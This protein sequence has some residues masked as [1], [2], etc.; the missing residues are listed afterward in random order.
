M[1][2]F[3]IGFGYD[4]HQLVENRPLVLG[5]IHISY[6]KGLEGHS[7]ADCLIHAIV[8]SILGAAGLRDIGYYFPDTDPAN[9]NKASRLFLEGAVREVS[10]RGFK[11]INVDTTIIAEAPKLSPY[12]DQMRK[13]LSQILKIEPECVGIKAT[14][15]EKMDATGEGRAIA[16]YAV[17]L[18]EKAIAPI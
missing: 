3:R 11:I 12:M 7:D 4:I 15:N 6:R 18:L 13:L 17:C 5:G 8:D 1:S 14:T 16:A 2:N 9:R 10:Q